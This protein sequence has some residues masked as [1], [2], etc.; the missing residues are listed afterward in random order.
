M[1]PLTTDIRDIRYIAPH[2]H[3][4]IL[5]VVYCLSG[6]VSV[7]FG[8]EQHRLSKGEF[9]SVD[10]DVHAISSDEPNVTVLFSF[11]LNE[12][13]PSEPPLANM[14]FVCPHETQN[15]MLDSKLVELNR[16]FVAILLSMT[17]TND[18]IRQS[19]LLRFYRTDI[20]DVLFR[21][22]SIIGY[23]NDGATVPKDSTEILVKLINYMVENH[24]KKI[25]LSDLSA[26]AAM[27][28]NYVSQFMKKYLPGYIEWL[29]FIRAS[30]SAKLLIE[31]EMSIDEVSLEIGFSDKKYYYSAFK[32][33][34]N[35]TPSEYRNEYRKL[36]TRKNDCRTL[37][38]SDI[39][40]LVQESAN[41][42]FLEILSR[43]AGHII[44]T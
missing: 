21:H 33:W 40:S 12:S 13:E 10:H 30:M 3:D 32:K 28:K 41:L 18:H 22:F 38:L 11:D 4:G 31:T 23:C 36:A 29:R 44:L 8:Y 27:N 7:S 43:P 14:Y 9:I 15:A 19:E 17:T 1:A 2:Y 5:E 35:C 24:R 34:F 25:S 37:S 42:L 20:L 26:L 39:S 6:S 16:L